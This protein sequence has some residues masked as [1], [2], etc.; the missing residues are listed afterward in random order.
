MTHNAEVT[1]D[2]TES[3][4]LL[5]V[6]PPEM[7]AH[8]PRTPWICRT[9]LR[10]SRDKGRLA[11]GAMSGGARG[12]M[13][14]RLRSDNTAQER[15]AIPLSGYYAGIC[16]RHACSLFWPYTYMYTELLSHPTSKLNPPTR[17]APAP[18]PP[19]QLPKTAKE[20]MLERART[21]FGSRL[22]G[23]AERADELRKASINVAGILVPPKPEEP[24]NC[25]MSGCVNCVWDL[26]RDELEEWASKSAEARERVLAQRRQA[27]PA[28][29]AISPPG[30]P[31]HVAT[32]MDDDGGGSETNWES[33]LE[34]SGSPGDLFQ[35]IPVGIRE[36]MKTEKLLRKKHGGDEGERSRGENV[37]AS[38]TGRNIQW[39]R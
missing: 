18:L 19:D 12:N 10:L 27:T 15:Q 4:L 25:C 39:V 31:H 34:M 17:T 3:R 28:G 30:M 37:R 2:Q 24:D 36:F 7:Q 21:V 13:H 22:S 26:Y 6:H 9:C 23:P 5:I 11:R 29:S 16:P 14:R 20:E 32:S 1:V 8:P 35:N 33:G 38:D